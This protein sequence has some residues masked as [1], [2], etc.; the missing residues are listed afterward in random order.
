[1]KGRREQ[2]TKTKQSNKTVRNGLRKQGLALC[3]A[4]TA[5]VAGMVIRSVNPETG[6]VT[7]TPIT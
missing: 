6:E 5:P 4:N 1:M 2:S 7:E 3:R